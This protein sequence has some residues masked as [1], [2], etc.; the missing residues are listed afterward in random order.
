MYRLSPHNKQKTYKKTLKHTFT[1]NSIPC[2]STECSCNGVID[3]MQVQCKSCGNGLKNVDTDG[4]VRE[5]ILKKIQH[6]VGVPGSEYTMNLGAL[7][8]W[9]PPTLPSNVNWNQYSD[10]PVASILKNNNVPSRG[11]STRSSITRLRPGS[12]SAPGKGVDVKHGSYAR[13]LARLKGSG[14]LR[15]QDKSTAAS[16][17]KYGGKTRKFNIVSGC[18]QNC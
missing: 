15:E 7:N 17:P 12:S 3:N 16:K 5:D 9:T 18:H 2:D 14:P 6:T 10:R 11:S 4:N 8:V 1:T 13:Y